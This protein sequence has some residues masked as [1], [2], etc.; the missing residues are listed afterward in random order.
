MFSGV[1]TFAIVTLFAVALWVFAESESLGEFS[2]LTS[3]R[4][5]SAGAEAGG[6]LVSPDASF[7]GS[8]TIDLVGSK[9]AISRSEG[10]LKRGIELSPGLS[11]VPTTDG[12]HTLNLLRVLQDYSPLKRTGV[13]VV[14]V[15]PQAVDVVVQELVTVQALVEPMLQGVEVVGEVRM[16][17][18][19][20]G[21]RLPRSAVGDGS[22]PIR[23][24]ARLDAS[25]TKRLPTSGPVKEE[26]SLIPPVKYASLP[27]FQMDRSSV[28]VEFTIRG[29][30]AT[31]TL[32]SVPVQVV[33]PPVE[34]G[35]WEVEVD[36]D[37]RFLSAEV[38]GPTEAVERLKNGSEAVIAVVALSSDDLQSQIDSKNVTFV[39]L[40]GGV[41][42][43]RPELQIVGEQSSVRLK[44]SPRGE[45]GPVP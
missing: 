1:R 40:R 9:A 7:D 15:T 11:G 42:T 22:E 16:T 39:V 4:F 13:R 14:A 33:L 31:E 41:F 36:S 10:E 2:G 35:R 8:I 28:D 18:D 3:L 21:V 37:D 30:S 5:V 43:L 20:V 19:R 45:S 26:V 23:I 27:G 34:V 29:R 17:P 44:I 38:S 24:A 12:R 6:R 25:Q 32:R